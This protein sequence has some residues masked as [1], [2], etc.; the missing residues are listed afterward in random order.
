VAPLGRISTATHA[1]TGT[2][3]L[4]P[5]PARQGRA[6]IL[7]VTCLNQQGR[8]ASIPIHQGQVLGTSPRSTCSGGTAPVHIKTDSLPKP[9]TAPRSPSQRTLAPDGK[10]PR[11]T[12]VPPTSAWGNECHGRTYGLCNYNGCPDHHG[13]AGLAHGEEEE[14]Y[15]CSKETRFRR[16][17]ITSRYIQVRWLTVIGWLPLASLMTGTTSD[18]TGLE[19]PTAIRPTKGWDALAATSTKRPS[20]VS[21]TPSVPPGNLLRDSLRCSV[22]DPLA[23][24]AIWAFLL[25]VGGWVSPVL[26][27]V[28]LPIHL[29]PNWRP[30]R[31]A[32]SPPAAVWR[33]H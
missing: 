21:A 33:G 11:N 10:L 14:G 25:A 2:I 24:Y 20:G 32:S 28:L 6:V 15:I 8:W 18:G 22:A 3:D 1:G 29:D 4:G 26:G 12:P 19:V 13:H 5:P 31:C 30:A 9:G 16:D 7:G 17:R 23:G 27:T